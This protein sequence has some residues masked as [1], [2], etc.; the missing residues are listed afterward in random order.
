MIVTSA[1][2]RTVLSMMAVQNAEVDC[3]PSEDGGWELHCIRPDGVTIMKASLHGDVFPEGTDGTP[4]EFVIETERWLKA[5]RSTGAS[6]EVSFP[7]GRVTLSGQGLRHTFRLAAVNAD[8]RKRFKVPELGDR[9]TAECMAEAERISA[10]LASVDPKRAD[11]V[12][13]E[14][15]PGGLRVSSFDDAGNGADLTLTPDECALLDG[16]ASA[17][18]PLEAW[19]ETVRSLPA[20]TVLDIRLGGDLPVLAE[21]GD[22]TFDCTWLCAPRIR[23]E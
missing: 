7:D 21:F 23:Q 20:D 16:E 13:F 15:S 14:V 19:S 10:L 1:P 4:D 9:L 22:K 17:A 3:R 8:N 2:L 6:T 12:V 18:F 11:E 5:L